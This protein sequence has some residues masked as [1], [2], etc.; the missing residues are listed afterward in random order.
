MHRLLVLTLA[1]PILMLSLGNN[2]FDAISVKLALA[3]RKQEYLTERG[4]LNLNSPSRT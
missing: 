1:P 3:K 2:L 4:A